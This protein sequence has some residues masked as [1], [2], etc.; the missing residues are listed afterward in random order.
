MSILRRVIIEALSSD[1][2]YCM[3]HL[4]RHTMLFFAN[5]ADEG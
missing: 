2:M 3:E 1:L 4:D 5:I